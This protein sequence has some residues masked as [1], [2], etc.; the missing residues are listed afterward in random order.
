MQKI[1]I[2]V[3]LVLNLNVLS[4]D[5]TEDS[6]IHLEC[7]DGDKCL[8]V[9]GVHVKTLNKGVESLLLKEGEYKLKILNE[10][11]KYYVYIDII[12]T[13]G[14]KRFIRVENS[15]IDKQLG[16][17][18][19]DNKI[20]PKIIK[21]W[22][23]ALKYCKKLT[24][25]GYSDWRL[26]AYEELLTIVDYSRSGMAIIPEFKYVERAFYWTYSPYLGDKRR[27][28]LISF[29]DGETSNHS[30]SKQHKFRCVRNK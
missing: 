1:L 17:M 7:R 9:N 29:K 15:V 4:A 26:P 19:Q 3:L 12:K 20:P 8:Y 14:K 28:W 24:L 6:N 23:K 21:T 22:K 27:S 18:W 25:L 10:R 30:K 13:L 11:G 5:D 16:L 2:I